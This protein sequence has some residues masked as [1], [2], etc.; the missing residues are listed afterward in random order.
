M[1]GQ[2]GSRQRIAEGGRAAKKP[3]ADRRTSAARYQLPAARYLIG[4]TPAIH[5]SSD[6]PHL[7]VTR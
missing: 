2:R 1:D 7:T 4:S 5:G 6:R 3:A